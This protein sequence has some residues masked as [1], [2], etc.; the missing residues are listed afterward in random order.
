MTA[1]P[2][3][4]L[5]PS[6]VWTH[7]AQFTSIARPSGQEAGMVKY[8]RAVADKQ[9]FQSVTDE[10]GNL[11]VRVPATKGLEGKARVILQGHMDMVCTRD[12]DAGEYDPSLGRIRVFRAKEQGNDVVEDPNGDWIKGIPYYARC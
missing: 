3:K 9:G 4:G 11:R 2:Y 12:A 10:A 5:E 1:D 7:F 6:Q 8:I